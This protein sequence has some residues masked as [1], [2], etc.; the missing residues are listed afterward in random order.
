MKNSIPLSSESAVFI[1]FSCFAGPSHFRVGN[2]IAEIKGIENLAHST[3][4][5]NHK[6]LDILK[7]LFIETALH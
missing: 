7:I 5:K 4:Q 2:I 6:I 1:P 3:L